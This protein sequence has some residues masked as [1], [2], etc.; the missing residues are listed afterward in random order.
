M[1]PPQVCVLWEG[2]GKSISLHT[3]P[4]FIRCCITFSL[5][6]HSFFQPKCLRPRSPSSTWRLTPPAL[7]IAF[8]S[9]WQAWP[10]EHVFPGIGMLSCREGGHRSIQLGEKLLLVIHLMGCFIC[11][12]PDLPFILLLHPQAPLQR[13][14]FSSSHLAALQATQSLRGFLADTQS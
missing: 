2:M 8:T 11:P 5:P 6:S 9:P 3:L 14:N 13:I 10:W 4:V 7:H 1:R 12:A